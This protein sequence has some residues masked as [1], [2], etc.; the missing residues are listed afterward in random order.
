MRA[1][2]PFVFFLALYAAILGPFTA[3]LRA[4]P[5]AEQIG[6][7]PHGTALSLITADQKL[8]SAAFFVSKVLI[9]F[10]SRG[11]LQEKKLDL[12]TDYPGMSRIL[13]AAVKLD[14][15]NMDAY[16][17]AQAVLVWDVGQVRL[18]N[19]LLEYGMRYRTW[20]YLLPF[21]A[22]FNY[23][24]FLKDN[25]KAAQ[26]YRRAAELSGQEL[27]VG[28]AGRFLY[29]SGQTVNAIAFVTVME[30][31]TRN[32]AV[33]RN[34]AVRLTALRRI[35]LIETAMS[36]YGKTH[37]NMPKSIAELHNSGFL[38]AVPADPYGGTFFIDE[39]GRVRTTS[40]L[41]YGRGQKQQ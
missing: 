37:G 16:Y 1:F 18:A 30:K 4:K 6:Y 39:T 40:N 33:K 11:E 15:Y 25:E 13:H 29:E 31:N 36:E 23:S 17:F 28:L 26:Y 35:L 41:A 8:S 32:E 27:H 9:Y 22:G 10:G 19:D 21:F 24:Y 5:F 14:P 2:V 20:D 34:L 38:K 12:P 7:I 3:Y